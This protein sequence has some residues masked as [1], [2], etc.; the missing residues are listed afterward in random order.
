M[1]GESGIRDT[2]KRA[3]LLAKEDKIYGT[4][5][6]LVLNWLCWFYYEKGQEDI[7]K[8]F[9]ELWEKLHNW[10]GRNWS[11]DWLE[12]YYKEID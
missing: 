5:L 11:K 3:L 7:S 10:I 12:Y 1:G 2:Y 9:Q 4:E 6:S 8:V